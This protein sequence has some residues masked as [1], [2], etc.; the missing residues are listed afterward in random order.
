VS[1]VVWT[2]DQFASPAA[3]PT[4]ML[5]KPERTGSMTISTPNS[6]HWCGTHRAGIALSHR[7][8]HCP[9]VTGRRQDEGLALPVIA[10]RAYSV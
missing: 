1:E 4:A 3:V 5:D 10:W 9:S 7:D 8:A 2:P 6:P